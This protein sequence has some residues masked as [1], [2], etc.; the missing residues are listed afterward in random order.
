[1]CVVGCCG[2]GVSDVQ[3]ESE[4]SHKVAMLGLFCIPTMNKHDTMVSQV[5]YLF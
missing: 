1:M 4:N 2:V 3:K 5:V